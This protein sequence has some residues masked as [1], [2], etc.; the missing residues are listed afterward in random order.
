[1]SGTFKRLSSIRS[2]LRPPRKKDGL[3][4]DVCSS[5]PE[6]VEQAGLKTTDS[7]NQTYFCISVADATVSVNGLLGYRYVG[8]WIN[9]AGFYC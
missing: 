7:S 4:K 1:M 3:K 6:K 5:M 9:V 8:I 2:S